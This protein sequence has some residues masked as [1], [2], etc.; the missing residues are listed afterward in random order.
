MLDQLLMRR[1]SL[2]KRLLT[3]LF[4]PLGVVRIL[5]SDFEVITSVIERRRLK[6]PPEAKLEAEYPEADFVQTKLSLLE[7]TASSCPT[8]VMVVISFVIIVKI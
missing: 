8:I 1:S 2:S 7:L 6:P 4:F 3:V 5:V